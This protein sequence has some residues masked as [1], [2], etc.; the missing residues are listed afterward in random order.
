MRVAVEQRHRGAHGPREP[1]PVR[2]P[3]LRQP[4][5][6][7][8]PLRLRR[9]AARRPPRRRAR[10]RP[11]RPGLLPPGVQ[12]RR[13]QDGP[14]RRAHRRPGRDPE[15]LQGRQREMILVGD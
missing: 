1:R 2:R 15:E 12:E 7:P 10:P 14:R 6:R 8:G 3:L 13:P 5:A 4:Q 11:H 9:R